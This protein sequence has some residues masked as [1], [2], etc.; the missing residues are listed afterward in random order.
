MTEEFAGYSEEFNRLVTDA[1]KGHEGLAIYSEWITGQLTSV[2]S[3]LG[4]MVQ[5]LE[6]MIDEP[7]KKKKVLVFGCG[8][9][10]SSVALALKGAEVYGVDISRNCIAIAKRRAVEHGV[11]ESV[12]LQYYRDTKRLDFPDN[13]F[14]I[15][16][17]EAV[18]EHITGDRSVYIQEMW[19]SLKQD[20]VL[21]IS[22]TPNSLYPYD[23]HTTRLLF[24]PWM[25]AKWA[26]RYAVFRGRCLESD[27]L[28]L[29]G[30][31]GMT[32]WSIVHALRG[33]GY[34]LIANSLSK[35]LVSYMLARK[36]LGNIKKKM[37]FPVLLMLNFVVA[38]PL[39]IPV[40]ALLPRLTFIGIRKR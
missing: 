33:K 7:I 14:D 10:G 25:S 35:N 22:N 28:E 5:Q 37:S 18:L 6:Y 13:E 40:G 26:K 36:R 27:D 3:Y 20:G 12:H 1:H 15:V 34:Y 9:G 19:R 23:G 17:C 2:S 29:M 30:R 11:S 8:F 38:L 39:Q 24:V 21:Y 32:Y 16:T 4:N 31:R